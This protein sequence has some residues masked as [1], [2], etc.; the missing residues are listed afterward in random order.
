MRPGHSVPGMEVS[1]DRIFSA[2]AGPVPHLAENGKIVSFRA[3]DPSVKFEASGGQLL[4]DVEIG[5]GKTFGLA[6]GFFDPA[7]PE[8]SPAQPNTGALL[9]KGPGRT[10][11]TVTSNLDRP[12]SVEIIGRDAYVV[13][14]PGQILKIR[15]D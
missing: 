4:V 10:F 5:G 2:Q 13:T 12:T 11:R 6:Q 14:I 9:K 7:S 1:G 8:G 3:G 15:V